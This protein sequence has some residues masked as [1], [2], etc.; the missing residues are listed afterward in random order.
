MLLL[1]QAMFWLIAGI[2]AAPFGLA[3]EVHMAG[4]ALTTM[5]LALATV[6]CAVGVLW[7][8]PAARALAIALEVIC[9]FGSALLWLLP[10]GFNTGLVSTL[11][12]VALPL[13]VIVLLR[14][15][16]EAAAADR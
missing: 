11:V 6:L 12:N 5:L 8:K 15:D 9:L 3:G 2:S 16:P 4:L 7:R 14:R 1:M 10:I 13:T